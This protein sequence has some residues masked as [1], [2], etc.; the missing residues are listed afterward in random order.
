MFSPGQDFPSEIVPT[1]SSTSYP[2]A[3]SSGTP[4]SAS[5]HSLSTGAIAGVAIGGAAIVILGAALIY[6]CGRQRTLGELLRSQPRSGPPSYMPPYASS[7]H[8]SMASSTPDH[9]PNIPQ[10]DFTAAP[11]QRYSAQGWLYE[12]SA[13][14]MECRRSFSRSPLVEG[15]RE[16]DLMIPSIYIAGT[17]GDMSPEPIQSP[18]IRRPVP[19]SPLRLSPIST[20]GETMY[21]PLHM[22]SYAAQPSKNTTSVAKPPKLQI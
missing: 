2:T 5:S 7:G 6:L 18:P 22:E 14:E 11:G 20:F 3:A 19:E 10:S 17:P 9:P 16:R 21:I 8:P 4:S 1:N 13:A 12:G 15:M